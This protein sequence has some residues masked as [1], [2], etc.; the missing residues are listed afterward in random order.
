MFSEV[1]VRRPYPG[2]RPFEPYEA[3]I[4]FG[5]EA[6]VD[7]LLKILQQERFLAVIGPSGCGKS[8]L[9]RAGLLPA[10]R[11]G[12]LGT[13]SDWRIGI[14]RPG[15]RPI[16]ELART[17]AADDVFGSEFGGTDS[18]GFIETELARGPRGLIDI[19]QIAAAR[20]KHRERLNLLVLV[21]QFEELFTYARSGTS[22]ANESGAFVNLL[23]AAATE[24]EAGI[25]IVLTMRTDFLGS[26]CRFLELPDAINRGMFLT[27]R[28]NRDE[29]RSAIVGPASLFGGDIDDQLAGALINGVGG[30]S[31]ELPILQHALSRVWENAKQ[32]RGSTTMLPE[33][34][35]KIGGL[36]QALSAHADAV[37]TSLPAELQ[38]LAKKL[39]QSITERTSPEDGSRDVRRPRPL[40]EIAAAIP[41]CEW[42]TLVPIVEAFAADGVNFLTC[43]SAIRA[44]SMI[45]ISHEA[46]IRK[47]D[48]LQKWVAEEAVRATGYRRLQ[49]RALNGSM[50]LTGIELLQAIRWRK[51]GDAGEPPDTSWATRYGVP[52]DFESTIA[53]I[54]NSEKAA[55]RQQQRQAGQR[56]MLVAVVVMIVAGLGYFKW[57][58]TQAAETLRDMRMREEAQARLDRSEKRRLAAE[59]EIRERNLNAAKDDKQRMELKLML[60]QKA[61]EEQ[62]KAVKAKTEARAAEEQARKATARQLLSEAQLSANDPERAQLLAIEAYQAD[63][64]SIESVSLIRALRL[65]Y[66]SL[67]HTLRSQTGRVRRTMFNPNG[68]TVLTIG[69]DGTAQIWEVA[70]GEPLPPIGGHG[71]PLTDAAYSSD[72]TLILTNDDRVV[73]VFDAVTGLSV[74]TFQH[75]NTVSRATFSPNAKYVA[76]ASGDKAGQVW[77]VA[78]KKLAAS[79]AGHTQPLT[80]IAY[81][82]DGRLIA[83]AS[84][85]NSVR[86]W[87]ATNGTQKLPPLIPSETVRRLV[88]S[89]DSTRLLTLNNDKTAQI[90]NTETGAPVGTSLTGHTGSVNQGAFSPDGKIVVTGGADGSARSWDAVTGKQWLF[91]VENGRRS[92]VLDLS[93]HRDGTLLIATA[94]GTAQLL[95][96][97]S[98][99]SIAA[100]EAHHG[101]VVSAA[102]SPDGKTIVTAHDDGARLWDAGAGRALVTLTGTKS[103]ILSAAFTS[104]G[105]GVVTAALDQETRVWDVGSWSSRV[106]HKSEDVPGW[107]FLSPDGSK[108]LRWTGEG[109]GSLFDSLTGRLLAKI[110]LDDDLAGVAFSRD[111]ERLLVYTTETV[112]VWQ[113]AHGTLLATLKASRGGFEHADFSPD[114]KMIVTTSKEGTSRLWSVVNGRP[115]HTLDGATSV[116]IAALVS[117]ESPNG[118][119]IE[120]AAFSPDGSVVATADSEGNVRLWDTRNGHSVASA[121]VHKKLRTIVFSP[122]GNTIITTGFDEKARLWNARTGRSIAT[123]SGHRGAVIEA[124]FTPDG[125]IVA[126]AGTDGTIRLWDTVTGRWLSLLE[127]HPRDVEGL[128]FSPNRDLLLSSGT[129]GTARVWDIS[130]AREPVEQM[131]AT[132]RHRVARELTADEREEVHLKPL[133]AVSVVKGSSQ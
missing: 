85:D 18:A 7:G 48:R 83:T 60:T 110:D 26:C 71:R 59:T 44:G 6:H 22:Q 116:R 122:D 99:A 107:A 27:P 40:Q 91:L 132:I 112:R 86:L 5:R 105:K 45:D 127:G 51:G 14:M 13:G 101:Q 29:M 52:Q 126:T 3:E 90:W 133:K 16:E 23:L 41:L 43:G 115:L 39:F 73:R 46:L 32:A 58:Q 118:N 95:E 30:D 102:F 109:K 66:G 82:P 72:G 34:L 88:F 123:L 53:Y 55:S 104:D 37:Y 49:E 67:L 97:R 70:T 61:A 21:D 81:S 24:G 1:E 8:S 69:G 78:T 57:Q 63:K 50:L 131:I 47:W 54:A 96:P 113:T 80:D 75:P 93:F 10:V 33:D 111:G 42:T 56:L 121:F 65:R 98:G 103:P 120:T 125:K 100:F 4:F 77:E 108:L 117:G 76:T 62:V 124:A 64:K 119:A 74:A 36:E 92:P 12:Y 68:K 128:F 20:V 15:N 19:F 79:L 28:L 89:P 94:D 17:L 11:A 31:D 9:V 2:L 84:R 129:D 25:H 35:E 106:S 87:D 38:P 114:Q 130:A